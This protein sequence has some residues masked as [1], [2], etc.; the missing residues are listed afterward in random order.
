M[1]SD[2]SVGSFMPSPDVT[3]PTINDGMTP[4]QIADATMQF[5]FEMMVF[6][7]VSAAN[8]KAVDTLEKVVD[9]QAN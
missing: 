8:N 2:A 3:R 7:S 5:Q 1:P 4:A 6:S 9:R